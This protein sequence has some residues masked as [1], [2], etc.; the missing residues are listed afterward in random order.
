MPAPK[1]IAILPQS[2]FGSEKCEREPNA[3]PHPDYL[4]GS[5]FLINLTAPN[6]QSFKV[7]S[8]FKSCDHVSNLYTIN[9]SL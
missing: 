1:I 5:A 4:S 8:A 3:A 2:K 9:K 7:N 6:K